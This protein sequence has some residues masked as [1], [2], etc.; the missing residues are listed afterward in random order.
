[1]SGHK[2]TLSWKEEKKES[3]PSGGST[4]LTVLVND[5]AARTEIPRGIMN[6]Q[7][8]SECELLIDLEESGSEIAARAGI[9]EEIKN[10]QYTSEREL[11]VDLEKFYLDDLHILLNQDGFPIWREMPSDEHSDVVLEIRRSF[12]EW[13]NGRP[14]LC[15]K[16]RNVMVDQSFNTPPNVKRCPDFAIFGPDRLNGLRIR[17]VNRKAM[18]PHVIIQFSWTSTF[19]YEK[20]AIDDMMM[21]GGMGEYIHLGRPNVAHLIKAL[22]GGP[23]RHVYG[24]EVFEV[25][26][27][28]RTSAEPTMRYRCVH[29]VQEDTVISIT[30]ESM[31]LAGDEGEPFTIAMTDIRAAL[32]DY[33]TFAPA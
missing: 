14:I 12:D 32:E 17:P 11:L 26:Q 5:I 23:E 24:F 8:T 3:S 7:Y 30:S 9:P 4:R 33:V 25:G 2:D 13:K 16:G 20:C 6:K 22:L 27:A 29:G 18:H 1:M 15:D 19:A 31:G 28:Q 21:Y 10:K